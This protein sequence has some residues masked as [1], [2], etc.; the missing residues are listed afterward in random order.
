[1]PLAALPL[2]ALLRRLLLL[3]LLLLL[4]SP[5]TGQP[6]DQVQHHL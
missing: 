4:L 2:T 6:G 1:L 3:L 5:P